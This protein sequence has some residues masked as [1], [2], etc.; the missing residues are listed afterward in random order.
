MA[1][2]V[3]I[4]RRDLFEL[5]FALIAQPLDEALFKNILY[6]RG[7][8]QSFRTPGFARYSFPIREFS[9]RAKGSTDWSG[10]MKSFNLGVEVTDAVA[11]RALAL[12][13]AR[14]S[15][16]GLVAAEAVL[17]QDQAEAYWLTVIGDSLGAGRG[18]MNSTKRARCRND[19]K[20]VLLI[21][22]AVR[23]AASA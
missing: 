22:R 15:A 11:M 20:I 7:A 14:P 9:P 19:I 3:I 12:Q 1:V 8:R 21:L 5:P 4:S 18:T 17:W 10:R 23:T 6:L 2:H 13:R 16:G